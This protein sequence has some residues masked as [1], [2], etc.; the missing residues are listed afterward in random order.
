MSLLLF[1]GKR[2]TSAR[3]ADTTMYAS[4]RAVSSACVSVTGR[5]GTGRTR[6]MTPPKAA[7]TPMDHPVDYMPRTPLDLPIDEHL[8]VFGYGSIVWKVGF[9]Y[10]E[11]VVC[12]LPGYRRRFHQGSTDHRGTVARPGR[13][14]TLEECDATK[15]P[16]CWG[17]A[18]R[19]APKNVNQ[20]L[21]LLEIREKQY[22]KRMQI[23]LFDGVDGGMN[24]NGSSGST[25][26]TTS[27]HGSVII[28][29]ALTYIATKDPVNLNWLGEPAGGVAES[30]AQIAN[31]VGPSGP[32]CAYLFNLCDAM[33]SIEVEDQYLFDLEREVRKI[34]HEREA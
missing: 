13:T 34:V 21:Q 6:T 15:E 24:G 30:A 9:E 17:A 19:V 28:R 22:D 5:T 16:P 26:T 23:D 14:V 31:A 3:F 27:S 1:S 12:C 11:R 8:W 18:Y 20:V 25:A 10:D 29:N 2:K 4:S 33:R 32:N 7:K